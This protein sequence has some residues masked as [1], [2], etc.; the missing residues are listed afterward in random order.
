MV[1]SLC[2]CPKAHANQNI[3]PIQKPI[4][5]NVTL[6]NNL[7]LTQAPTL[8]LTQTLTMALSWFHACFAYPRSERLTS[9]LVWMNQT[10]TSVL[11][12]R[13]RWFPPS[14]R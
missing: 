9:A 14:W 6:N 13:R 12:A 1:E 5:F 11:K 4:T 8:N 7:N 2:C 3:S 10:A